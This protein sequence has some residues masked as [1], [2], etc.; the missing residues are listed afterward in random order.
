[1]SRLRRDKA[2]AVF[3]LAAKDGD[4]AGAYNAAVNQ[5]ERGAAG[6]REATLALL[7]RLLHKGGKS[8]ARLSTQES[9][10]M[11]PGS[12]PRKVIAEARSLTRGASSFIAEPFLFIRKAPD[13]LP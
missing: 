2:L 3:E 6:F 9:C 1:M 13:T 11:L 10:E 7:K 5:L 8:K 4:P 12:E